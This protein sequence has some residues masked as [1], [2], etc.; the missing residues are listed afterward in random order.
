MLKRLIPFLFVSLLVGCGGG[1]GGTSSEPTSSSAA[2]ESLAPQVLKNT[3][4]TLDETSITFATGVRETSTDNTVLHFDT[5][6]FTVKASDGRTLPTIY[7]YGYVATGNLGTVMSVRGGDSY[8][9]DLTFTD[10]KSGTFKETYTG[11]DGV[12][13]L[14]EG[15]FTVQDEPFSFLPEN[16]VNNRYLLNVKTATSTLSADESPIVGERFE[17][18]FFKDNLV[19]RPSDL[20]PKEVQASYS[21]TPV[22]GSTLEING[23]YSNAKHPYKLTARFDSLT[24]GTFTLN[25]GE[26]KAVATGDFNTIK[27]TPIDRSSMKG[28]F[29]GATSIT[30]TNTKITYPYNVYLPPGYQTS[31]KNYPVIYVTDGQWYWDFAYLLEKKSKD[32]IMVSIEQGPRDRRMIDFLPDGAPLYTKVLK[33]ELIPLIESTYRTNLERTF[34]GVSAGGLLGAYLLSVEP[35]GVPYFKNYMLIDGALFAVTS[36]IINAE[37]LRFRLNNSLAVNLL[38]AGTPQGNGWFVNDFERRYKSRSYSN[39]QLF[40]KEFRVTHDEMGPLAFDDLIERVY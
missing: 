9:F 40:N 10:K 29:V 24:T 38:L 31:G 7:G 26:G 17:M 25:I 8:R 32:F 37:G 11:F 35:V 1:G 21:I 33:E 4:I 39:F 15:N 19:V 6:Q 5:T 34:V 16:I 23:V 20:L 18:T 12:L 2:S 36:D 27:I 14:R 3:K 22:D 13:L 28:R 30:S